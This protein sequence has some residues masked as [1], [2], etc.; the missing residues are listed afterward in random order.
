[1]GVASSEKIILALDVEGFNDAEKF[2][3]LLCDTV[4]VFKVG[5]QLFTRCGPEIVE[6]IHRHG[7]KVFLDLKFHDIPHTVARAVEEACRLRVFMLTIHAMGGQKMIRD[8][9]DTS[10]KWAQNAS[11]PPPL[12]LAVTIL[13]SL[14]QEDLK[15]IGIVSPVE[16]AVLR[17]AEL[18]RHAGVNGVIASAREASPIRANCGN[19]FIIV[20]PGI[21]PRGTAPDDQKRTVT[22][23]EALVAGANY[24]VVGRP[25]LKA[26]DPLK[27]A[28]E[29]IE[30]LGG[31]ER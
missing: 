29:I 31:E 2:V 6:M 17:L 23:K 7:G 8:A 14:K 13:T 20:T 15:D 12:I 27:A 16:E 26:K 9:V 4:G 1:M 24:I 22:P 25:I 19:D 5:K 10:T 11:S 3:K 30:E 18:S 21:R 28:M